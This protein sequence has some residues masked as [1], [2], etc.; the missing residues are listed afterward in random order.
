MNK[1]D[2]K[3]LLLV[4]A[5]PEECEPK[6]VDAAG[7]TKKQTNP[8]EKKPVD[9]KPDQKHPNTSATP[10][11]PTASSSNTK[12]SEAPLSETVK[13]RST[14]TTRNVNPTQV[15]R[16]CSDMDSVMDYYRD[17]YYSIGGYDINTHEY[18]D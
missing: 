18:N 14:D 17:L 5:P 4:D 2:F 8:K 15:D 12:R 3:R 1:L 11:Q 6:A 16:E 10:T 13:T 7:A 9:F